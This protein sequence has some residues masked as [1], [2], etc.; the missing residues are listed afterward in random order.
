MRISGGFEGETQ[1][2]ITRISLV[3]TGKLG[4]GTHSRRGFDSRHSLNQTVGSG[5]SRATVAVIAAKKAEVGADPAS[6]DVA[7]PASVDEPH[8]ELAVA[9]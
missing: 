6:V 7:T 1:G 4:I 5:L 9:Q 3:I 8:S 2:P